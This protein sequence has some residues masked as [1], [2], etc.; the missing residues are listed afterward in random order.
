[1]PTHPG[2]KRG[3]PAVIERFQRQW[4][5]RYT[6]AEGVLCYAP[7]S[8]T[9]AWDSDIEANLPIVMKIMPDGYCKILSRR[10]NKRFI[11]IGK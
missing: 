2:K 6:N 3:I 11:T 9:Q 7:V 1:M 5:A 10:G 8:D 4:R